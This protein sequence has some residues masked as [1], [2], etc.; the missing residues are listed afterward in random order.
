MKHKI[1]VYRKVNSKVLDYLR[2]KCEVIYFDQLDD[3][4]YPSFEAHLKDTHVLMGSGLKIDEELLDKCPQLKMVSNISVGYDNLDLSL[5]TERNIVA[6]N[7]PGVLNETVADAV[8]GVLLSAARRIPELDAYVK[9]GKWDATITEELFGLDVHGKVIGIVGMGG[10]GTAI[11]KRA[12]FG[13]GMDVLYH[14]RSRNEEAESVFN[15]AYCNLPDLLKQSDFVCSMVPHSNVTK[16]L[17]SKEEFNMMKKSAIFINGS[18]GAVVDEDALYEALINK[19]IAGAGLDVYKKEPIDV[20]HPLLKLQNVVTTP[21]IGSATIETRLKM[22]M[23][24][25][26][27]ILK[28]LAGEIPT[29]V[30]NETANIN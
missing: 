1:V 6:T 13:F 11:A 16:D 7:T 9:D 30:L 18:R 2:Q 22:G 19:E 24:A 3:S 28:V 17:F 25:A 4:S 10:I 14:N 20:E 27:S 21:H 26:N 12:H 5:L 15:A 23:L 8:F 29:N